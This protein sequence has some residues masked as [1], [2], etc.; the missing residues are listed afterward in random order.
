MRKQ[1]KRRYLL[2]HKWETVRDTGSHIYITCA[3]CGKRTVIE[4]TNG[5]QPVDT[6]W[7]ET[8]HWQEMGSP[9]TS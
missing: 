4:C 1:R 6:H 5:Y 9:P 2:F 8:G 3:R 7:I